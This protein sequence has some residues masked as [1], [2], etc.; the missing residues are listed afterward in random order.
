MDELREHISVRHTPTAT[1]VTCALWQEGLS[2]RWAVKTFVNG[3]KPGVAEAREGANRAL[4]E[5]LE[6]MHA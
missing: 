2:V 4:A 6:V 5:L 3:I 1:Y